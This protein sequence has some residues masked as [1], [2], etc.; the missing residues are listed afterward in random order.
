MQRPSGIGLEQ[1]PHYQNPQEVG[2]SGQETS[3]SRRDPSQNVLY[4]EGSLQPNRN[5]PT[6]KTPL[7]PMAPVDPGKVYYAQPVAK[8]EPERPPLPSRQNFSRRID[9][10]SPGNGWQPMPPLA[11]L[12]GQKP[13]NLDYNPD[14]PGAREPH[15]PTP[16]TGQKP[17]D[18][19][20]DEPQ[21]PQDPFD[22]QPPY[23][24][25]APTPPPG[26]P[27]RYYPDQS[28]SGSQPQSKW[29]PY[30]PN[31]IPHH[32]KPL[33]PPSNPSG[34]KN[35]SLPVEESNLYGGLLPPKTPP[36]MPTSTSTTTPLPKLGNR[37][38]TYPISPAVDKNAPQP[39]YSP[40]YAGIAHSRNASWAKVPTTSTTPSPPSDPFNPEY[41]V[42]YDDDDFTTTTTERQSPPLNHQF[43]SPPTTPKSNPSVYGSDPNTQLAMKEALKLMLRPYF[44]HSGNAEDKLAKQT[45]SALVS[46][47][48]RPPTD[49]TFSTT[50]TTTT[51][52]PEA[53]PGQIRTMTLNLLKPGSR[54]AWTPLKMTMFFQMSERRPAPS[55]PLIP[56]Q[57][58]PR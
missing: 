27:P 7:A 17:L 45:E 41:D 46:A 50:S 49:T 43:Y 47:I 15:N 54:R 35:P 56:V 10:G 57:P 51:K 55:R 12:G 34:S 36:S 42:I 11:P 28:P 33:A 53:H 58:T 8:N 16:P 19:D 25:Q 48:S 30:N 39:H 20:Y 6:Y 29:Q 5:Y 21:T 52:P 26:S 38:Y 13:L 1:N 23:P 44:N 14:S 9:Y 18:W 40:S 24:G 31:S 2:W 37:L 3:Y 22:E 4:V 32:Q